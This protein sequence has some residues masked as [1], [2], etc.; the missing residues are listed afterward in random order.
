VEPPEGTP[1]SA[2]L[3]AYRYFGDTGLPSSSQYFTNSNNGLYAGVNLPPSTPIRVEAW[4]DDGVT[5]RL[6][7]C[8][9]ILTSADAV[10]FLDMG[11]YRSDG[12]TGCTETR[13]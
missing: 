4:E 9:E 1:G 8:E 3:P 11:P 2:S 10:S 13:P 12:P 5:A 7:S 6:W